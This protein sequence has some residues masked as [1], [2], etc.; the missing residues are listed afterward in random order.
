MIM[1]LSIE[2]QSLSLYVLASINK[3]SIYSAESGVKYFILGALSS[4]ILLYGF[5]LVYGFTGTTYDGTTARW[6]DNRE[7]GDY[8]VKFDGDKFNNNSFQYIQQ[9][10]EILV[11]DELEVGSFELDIFE[12]NI[13]KIKTYE[14]ELIKCER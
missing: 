4:G 12:I 2:L 11:N 6:F 7:E 9:L 1:Y 8:A 13:N 14:E 3:N 10:S 5:S